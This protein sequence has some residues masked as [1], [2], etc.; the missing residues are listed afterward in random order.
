MKALP[1]AILIVVL[2]LLSAAII[3]NGVIEFG[4]VSYWSRHGVLLLFFLSMFPRLTLL[5]S[6]IPFGGLWW[7][8]GFIFVPRYLIA[9]LATINYGF[10]NPL[11]VTV[12]WVFALAGEST[13]KYVVQRR[14]FR[15]SGGGFSSRGETIDVD[16]RSLD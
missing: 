10:T 9:M 7:W 11:L 12:A 15:R 8:L 16:S 6:S 2:T 13:E 4:T 3:G 14:V 5:L 1:T